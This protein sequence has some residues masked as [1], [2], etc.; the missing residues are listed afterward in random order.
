MLT[1]D[2]APARTALALKD[3]LLE[4][5]VPVPGRR[6]AVAALLDVNATSTSGAAVRKPG[7]QARILDIDHRTIANSLRHAGADGRRADRLIQRGFDNIVVDTK[8]SRHALDVF[9]KP[10][11]CDFPNRGK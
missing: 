4:Q 3:R 7:N 6:G 10:D 11:C 8:P 1:T 9:D 2:P 5:R